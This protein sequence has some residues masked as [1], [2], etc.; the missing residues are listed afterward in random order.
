MCLS[1]VSLMAQQW[2]GT[3]ATA[4]EKP[5]SKGDVPQTL[6]LADNTL[7]QVVRVPAGSTTGCIPMLKAT[8]RWAPMPQQF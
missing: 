8:A 1:A 2:T 7:R 5:F 4:T 6:Q 3:W